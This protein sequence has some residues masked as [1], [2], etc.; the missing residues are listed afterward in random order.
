MFGYPAGEAIGRPAGMLFTPEDRAAGVPEL[1]LSTAAAAGRAGDDR[2]HVRRDGGRF[3]ANG[4]VTPLR[5][6]AGQVVGFTKVCRDVTDQHAT[7]EALSDA[8][9][10]SEAALLAGDMGT[11]EWDV[12]A[13]HLNGDAN[14]ARLF[15]VT[16]DP[17]GSTPLA[18]LHGVP[19]PRR[20]GPRVGRAVAASVAT[21]ADYECEYRVGR[22][23]G[24]V[25]WVL[26]RGRMVTDDAGRVVRFPG[27]VIDITARKA[28]QLAAADAE[29]RYRELF[30]S[31]D[32]GYCVIEVLY[33]AARRADD[34]RFELVNPAFVAQS[35]IADAVLAERC[36]RSPPAWSRTGPRRTA[37]VAET[38]V[39]E[40]FTEEFAALNA[41]FDVFAFRVGGDGS[42]RVGVLFTN[43]TDRAAGPSGT[44]RRHW[45]SS[46]NCGPWPSRRARV[47]DD[48]LATISH[49]L[50]TPLNA[51]VGWAQLMADGE[52][53]TSRRRD[54]PGG[55]RRDRPQRFAAEPADRGHS[56]CEPDHVRQAADRG[57]RVGPPRPGGGGRGDRPSGGERPR[58]GPGG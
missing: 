13:D 28:A 2:W 14:F 11:F 44:G 37:R 49:E 46:G 53:G 16:P 3:F 27:V 47:K 24:D 32:E 30:T 50:R 40:R 58:P 56:G 54:D 12:S 41:T 57:R 5:D 23:G 31:M 4:V 7:R 17:D 10:R 42:R 9:R 18:G 52:G 48:F 51:I 15:P 29:N 43:V 45:R 26:A 21:G 8:K 25:R 55:D 20:P 35:G 22:P 39:S 19:P 1:E 33:D 36:G 34:Y 6:G 38:G